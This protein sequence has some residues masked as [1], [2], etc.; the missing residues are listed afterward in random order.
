M[1]IYGLFWIEV[2]LSNRDVGG[3]GG[4]EIVIAARQIACGGGANWR[5]RKN[6]GLFRYALHTRGR[7][8]RG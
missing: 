8:D 4:G 1:N 5:S 6:V 7:R 3:G 2:G